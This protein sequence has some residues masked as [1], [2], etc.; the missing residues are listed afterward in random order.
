MDRP[1]IPPD[2]HGHVGRGLAAERLLTRHAGFA[3]CIAKLSDIYGRKGMLLVSWVL[4]MSF[5]M[6][7]AWSNS[8]T[9]L[10]APPCSRPAARR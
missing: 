1:R 9:A 8:M 5:S 7:C 2:I 3:V 6:G 10:C 4:F